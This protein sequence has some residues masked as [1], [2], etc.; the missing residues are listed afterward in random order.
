MKKFIQLSYRERQ[1]IYRGLCEGKSQREIAKILERPPS[2][3]SRE[4]ARNSDQIG[5]L[6]AGEAHAMTQERKHKNIPKVDKNKV[7]KGYIIQ[8][9]KE[10]LSPKMIAGAW[11][12]ENPDHSITAEAIYQWIY[13]VEGEKLELK[14][15]LLRSR[16]KRGLKRKPRVTQIKDRVSIHDRPQVINARLEVGHF[17]GDLIFNSGSQSKNV[18]TLTERVTR[19]A[20]LIRNENKRSETV[21]D[22]LIE[23]IQKT[24]LLIKSITFDNGSEFADHTK[25]NALGVKTY[26]CNPGSPW[27]KGSIENLNGVLRRYLPFNMPANEISDELVHDINVR[28]NNMP[29]GILGFKTSQQVF[30]ESRV[31][32]ALPA[33]EAFHN[34]SM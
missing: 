16:K 30:M 15:L 19:Y 14:K 2:T 20:V 11:S 23:H 17:E 21:I 3:V 13:E 6:Y 22:A 34:V 26:F 29:R 27:Q 4:I 31:K 32:S 5:Y 12:L 18:L 24:G 10:R 1:K 33:V 7:L 28:V 25:L 8:G 9:L